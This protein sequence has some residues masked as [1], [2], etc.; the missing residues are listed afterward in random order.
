MDRGA[1]PVVAEDGRRRIARTDV[2][3]AEPRLAEAAGR[4]GRG[5][6]KAAVVAAQRR[7]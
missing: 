2:L 5:V 3:L 4:L 1:V 7:A 6:V